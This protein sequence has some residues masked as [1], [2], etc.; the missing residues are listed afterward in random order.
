[1]INFAPFMKR[2]RLI[3][4]FLICLVYLS[5]NGCY[6]FREIG[7]IPP[8]ADTFSVDYFQVRAPRAE[9]NLGQTTSESLKDLLLA[10]TRLNLVES[11]G[12]IQYKGVIQPYSI[13]PVA[14]QGEEETASRTRLTV[15]IK[16]DYIDT[17]QKDKDKQFTV[18]QFED[19][20]SDEN[21]ED[22][23]ERLVEEINRKLI[24]DI[25]DRTL[26]DW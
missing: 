20:L 15:A 12:D 10:Q 8:N 6:G 13:Q 5:I 19:F 7:S 11:D 21:F 16:I 24:Q 3:L 18:S 1:M 4:P 23:Q 14:A 17:T 25:F 26:G 22:V 2:N 9:P